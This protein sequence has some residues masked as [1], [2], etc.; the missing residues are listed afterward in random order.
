MLVVK[1]PLA[2]AGDI[3][4]K[5]LIPGSGRSPGGGRGHPLQYSCLEKS[6]NREA[7]WA[8]VH[9]IAKNRTWLKWLSTLPCIADKN[10]VIVSGGQLTDITIHI[11]VPILSQ[12]LCH[13]HCHMALSRALCYTVG[14]CWVSIL[15]SAVCA[16]TSQDYPS[17]QHLPTGNHKFVL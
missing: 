15:N 2:N 11:H 4:D 6:M 17:P 8:A 10:F 9:R 12:L 14:P 5:G 3:R 13:P 16:W 1:N 7:W